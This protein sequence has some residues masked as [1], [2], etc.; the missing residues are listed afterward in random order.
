METASYIFIILLVLVATGLVVVPTAFGAVMQS[1]A[2]QI[3]SDSVNVGGVDSGSSASYVVKDTVGESGTGLLAGTLYA[4]KAGYRQLVNVIPSVDDDSGATSG[5]SV[6]NGS[7]NGLGG[8]GLPALIISSIQIERGTD[9]AVISW[10]TSVPAVSSIS[11][12]EDLGYQ[13]GT[14]STNVAS[15]EHSFLIP[16][17]E[18]EKVYYFKFESVDTNNQRSGLVGEVLASTPDLDIVA[19]ENPQDVLIM[20][21]DKA[22]RLSWENPQDSDFAQV[23]VVRSESFYPE[24]LS[25]GL[26]IYRGVGESVLDDGIEINTNYFYSVF[27]VDTAGNYSSGALVSGRIEIKGE[28]PIVI[29]PNIFDSI[30][31]STEVDPRF[32]EVEFA[33]FKVYQSGRL[34][35][36]GLGNLV[37]DGSESFRISIGYGSLPEVL[38]TILVTVTNAQKPDQQFSFLLR[39]NRGSTAYEASIGAFGEAGNYSLRVAIIDHDNQAIKQIEGNLTAVYP[40]SKFISDQV[41]ATVHKVWPNISPN[42]VGMVVLLMVFLVGIGRMLLIVV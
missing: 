34:I 4:L 19:P 12:G 22:V 41:E 39:V 28:T 17:L 21:E 29:T 16:N 13:S 23:V 38:K 35:N 7:V 32:A 2:Y 6:G 24:N 18:S 1:S 20:A 37:I 8:L 10:R 26:L 14:L 3:Q 11:W 5:S 15:L 30:P 40:F 25:D 9:S 27:A 31:K 36:S 33:D 42:E